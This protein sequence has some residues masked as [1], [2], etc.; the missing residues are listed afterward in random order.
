MGFLKGI[1]TLSVESHRRSLLWFFGKCEADI[2]KNQVK[3]LLKR[4]T[5]LFA[6]EAGDSAVSLFLIKKI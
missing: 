4:F 5:N 2:D 3:L 1:R 6:S